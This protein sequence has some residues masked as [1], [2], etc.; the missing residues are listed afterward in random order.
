MM[1]Y[2]PLLLLIILALLLYNLVHILEAV[3]LARTGMTDR[4]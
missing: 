3:V 1:R 2:F 4:A